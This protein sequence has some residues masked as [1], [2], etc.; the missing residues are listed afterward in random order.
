MKAVLRLWLAIAAAGLWLGQAPA[1]AQSTPSATTNTPAS[2]A[3]GPAQLQNFNL[4]G[5]VTKPA[6]TAPAAPSSRPTAAPNRGAA[7][8]EASDSGG[9]AASEARTP[10][11][12]ARTEQPKAPTP[13]PTRT[14]STLPPPTLS[15]TPAET[16]PAPAVASLPLAQSDEPAANLATERSLPVWPWLL[17]ALAMG[18][19]A[20]FLFWRRSSSRFAYAGGPQVDAFVA[21]EPQ[22]RAAVPPPP[23]APA[24][25]PPKSNGFVSTKMRPW[26]ELSFEPL[27]CIIEEQRV[28]FEFDLELFNS[29]N[30]PARDILIDGGLFDAG[31][32]QAQQI[33]GYFA[34]QAERGER[35]PLIPPLQRVSLRPQLTVPLGQ[36]RMLE[37]A[38]RRFFV[39]LIALNATYAWGGG[40]GQTSAAWLLGRD[41]KGEKLGPFRVDLG[42][43]IFRGLGAR[44][45]PISVRR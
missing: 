28:T 31:P 36:F 19:G 40:E 39:P 10:R 4:Q 30:A 38:G 29:G 15:I 26:L 7:T 35:I 42:P 17:A 44:V 13:A 45:L 8:A 18:V 21:P 22:P 12:A 37:A 23:A 33:G 16:A 3:I 2:D 41:T 43:R 27:R 25:A 34:S 1:L 32:E 24:P 5:T 9:A 20:A 11:P 14:A 6:E